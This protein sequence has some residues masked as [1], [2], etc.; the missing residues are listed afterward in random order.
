MINEVKACVSM[1]GTVRHA[2]CYAL[3]AR[4]LSTQFGGSTATN[5][6]FLIHPWI[7]GCGPFSAADAQMI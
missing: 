1:L 3:A 7:T 4:C 5:R 6:K 2:E